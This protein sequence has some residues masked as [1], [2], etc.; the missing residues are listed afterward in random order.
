VI[1]PGA[2][3]RRV[4]SSAV[5]VEPCR[6]L[7]EIKRI[8]VTCSVSITQM[9]ALDLGVASLLTPDSQRRVQHDE[10]FLPGYMFVGRPQRPPQ[11][12]LVASSHV[13]VASKSGLVRA[14]NEDSAYVG[15]WLCAVA[16]GWA[17]M[18]PGMSQARR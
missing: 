8:I 5:L 15:R 6:R 10:S 1:G 18:R 12:L 14:R 4:R 3:C 9:S 13:T 11:G 16:D 7:P 2:I 17:A